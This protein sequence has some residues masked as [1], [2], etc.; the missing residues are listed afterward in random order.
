MSMD[1]EVL[2][3]EILWALKCVKS[4][5]SFASNAGNNQLFASMFH[6]SKIAQSYRMSETK[7][8]YLV[9]FGICPWILE[10]LKNDL[11]GN[12]FSFLFDETTTSQIKKQFDGYVRF[13]SRQQG[14]IVDRYC[15]SLFLGHCDAE[16]LVNTF[17]DFGKRMEWEIE[18]LLQ[19]MM[20]GPRVNLSFERKLVDSLNRTNEKS[21]IDIGTCNLHK[22]NNG[23]KYGLKKL[24]FDFEGFATDLH[25]FF[26]NSSARRSDYQFMELVTEVET[27]FMIKHVSSRWL[28]LKKVLNRIL[29]QWQN[30][31][32]Y[33]LKFLPKEKRFAKEIESTD[34]YQRIRK[35]LTSETSRLYMSFAVYLADNLESFIIQ[36]QCSKPMVHVLYPAMGDLFFKLMGNFVKPKLLRSTDGVKDAHELGIINIEKPENL[37]S[38]HKIEFGSKT[39]YHIGLIESKANLDLIKTEMKMAYLELTTYF[40]KNL[41]HSN[42]ILKQLQYIHPKKI[43]HPN[44]VPAIRDLASIITKTL[45]GSKFTA[46]STE[47]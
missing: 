45:K 18:W 8:K 15:G 39:S 16:H 17:F 14:N 2:R 35:L 29:D 5:F 23:Y 9:Q 20:D 40:Q 4:T 44:A 36:F 28:S 22:V 34:R 7:C 38:L 42:N 37:L 30:L 19:I 46:L 21:M 6:D 43:R 11:K 26:K 24:S 25:F 13:E 27:S 12:P 3:A 41:P 32:E 1:D 47:R 10:N 31:H 33:F